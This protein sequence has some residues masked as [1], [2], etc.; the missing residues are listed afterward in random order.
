MTEP[1]DLHPDLS[2]E[3]LQAVV[4]IIAAARN[5][6]AD[7]H[8]PD[9]GEGAWSLGCRVLERTMHDISVAAE[10]T[11]WLNVVDPS[12]HFR[13]AVGQVPL[14]IYKGDPENPN[15]RTLKQRLPELLAAQTA[16]SFHDPTPESTAL[17]IAVETNAHGRPVEISLVHL[18]TDGQD[19]E[20]LNVWSLWTA[21]NGYRWAERFDHP[22]VLP[23]QPQPRKLPRPQLGPKKQQTGQLD[24]TAAGSKDG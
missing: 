4:D 13:F 5:G 8:D 24:D 3:R 21:A 16:F 15:R 18:R 23:M 12:R 19:D 22:S 10:K 1:F 9:A 7:S 11:A 6:G 2:H 14:G 20:V 17:R